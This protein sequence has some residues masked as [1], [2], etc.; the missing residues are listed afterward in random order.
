MPLISVLVRPKYSFLNIIQ[1]VVAV[2]KLTG[3]NNQIGKDESNSRSNYFHLVL[4][5]KD[6]G[7]DNVKEHANSKTKHWH[8]ILAQ[9]V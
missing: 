5:H 6:V 1:K 3:E 8:I 2:I 7:E 4:D 9:T